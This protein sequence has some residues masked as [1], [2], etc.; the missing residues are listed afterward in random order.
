MARELAVLI[1]SFQRPQ[2]LARVLASLECQQGVEGRFEVVV[3]DDGSID[4]TREVVERFA[5]RVK[6]PVRFTS[7][8]HQGYQLAR[9]RNEGVAVTQSPYL[10]FLDGDCLMPPTHLQ[11]HLRRRATGVVLGGYCCLLDRPTTEELTL[12]DVYQGEFMKLA[13]VQEYRKLAKLARRSWLYE[14]VRHPT[15]PRLY[16]GNVGIHRSDYE[17]INGYDEN[18]RGWGCEDDDLRLRL[19]AAGVRIRSILRW[20]CTYHLWHPKGE[21]TP[22]IWREGPNV[23]YLRRPHRPTVCQNGLAKYLA[24]ET[25]VDVRGWNLSSPGPAERSSRAAG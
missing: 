9:C 10:L 18:F 22:Q 25:K 4:S 21:T 7:H 1:S 12:Q 23:A 17:R 24:G 11:Q 8:P 5:S 14:L 20:T 19:R 6:F 2:H 3:T 13:S 15:K 16:G